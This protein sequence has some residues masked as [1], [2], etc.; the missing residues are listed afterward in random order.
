MRCTSQAEINDFLISCQNFGYESNWDAIPIHYENYEFTEERKQ[1]II[2]ETAF[3]ISSMKSDLEKYAQDPLT[4][5]TGYHVSGT[6]DQAESDMWH[7]MRMNRVTASTFKEWVSSA[8]RAIDRYWNGTED[9]SSL[10]SINP[11]FNRLWNLHRS[12]G[13]GQICPE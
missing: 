11:I 5:S 3:F 12:T 2:N 6:D 9:I 1:E 7:K 8:N 4:M 10:P 13:G